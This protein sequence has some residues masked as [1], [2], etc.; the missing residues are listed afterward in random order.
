MMSENY[1]DVI[2]SFIRIYLV[3]Q[4]LLSLKNSGL[5]SSKIAS[6]LG[7]SLPFALFFVPETILQPYSHYEYKLE[8]N[9]C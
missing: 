6:Y 8:E 9:N 7:L 5:Y 2:F 3:S 4:A 1:S